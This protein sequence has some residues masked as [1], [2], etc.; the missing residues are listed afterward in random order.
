[1]TILKGE[2]ITVEI[3]EKV[4]LKDISVQIERGKRTAI[5][6]PNGSGKSTLLKALSGLIKC[7]LGSISFMEEDIKK[8]GRRELAQKM[9]ILPQAPQVP[10]DVTVKDLVEY[11]RFPHRKWWGKSEFDEKDTVEW[12]LKQTGIL[13]LQNR[14]VNTLSGGERQR[15]WIAM[16]LAQQPSLLML[17][18]PTT[19]LDISHQLEV[20]NIISEL[21]KKN[22]ISIIMVLHDINHAMQFADEVIIVKDGKIE[23]QGSPEDVIDVNMFER[24][25]GVT[26]EV[27]KNKAGKYI[28][29]P[30]QLE[31]S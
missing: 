9:A 19:Y 29:M 8:M 2:H 3:N 7:K 11:G 18:E 13:S 21:N 23:G 14:L 10:A 27:F 31:K 28:F 6:G 5:I 1:M 12:A 4:I 24:V 16:A 30:I 20:M 15:A 17:D 25:F 22:G 26:A